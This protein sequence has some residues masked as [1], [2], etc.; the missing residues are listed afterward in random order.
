MSN[1]NDALRSST[2]LM[3]LERRVR[4]DC[5]M[6]NARPDPL[7][8]VRAYKFCRQSLSELAA[9]SLHRLEQRSDLGMPL[10]LTGMSRFQ[11][12]WTHRT[13]AMAMGLTQEA[14]TWRFLFV[15]PIQVTR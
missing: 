14:L 13:P 7:M 5:L 6:H 2:H 8:H 15:M 11:K 9:H 10:T 12:K 3:A 4:L 1:A